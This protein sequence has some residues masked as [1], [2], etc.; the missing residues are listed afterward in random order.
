[1]KGVPIFTAVALLVTSTSYAQQ[2]NGQQPNV[3]EPPAAPAQ[4]RPPGIGTKPATPAQN[5]VAVPVPV[6]PPKPNGPVQKSLVR[7]TATEVA[8]DYRAPWNAGMLGGGVG[9][10]FVIGGDCLIDTAH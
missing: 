7:I 9:R 1:M 3:P 6:A 10:R 5:V 2:E 8:P 4:Q